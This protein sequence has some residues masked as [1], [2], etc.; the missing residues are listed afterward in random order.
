MFVKRS[1][2]LDSSAASPQAV[3]YAESSGEQA[4]PKLAL[5]WAFQAYATKK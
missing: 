2:R 1:H 3:P 4:G 5:D